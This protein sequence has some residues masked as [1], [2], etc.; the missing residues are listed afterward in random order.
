MNSDR[1]WQVVGKVKNAGETA[2]VTLEQPVTTRFVLVYLTSL[3]QEEPRR[4]RGG[5]HEVEVYR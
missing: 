4:Y 3:P 2:E 5:I 1:A